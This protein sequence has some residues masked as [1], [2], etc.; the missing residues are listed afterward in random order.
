MSGMQFSDM[1]VM[2]GTAVLYAIFI[3]TT[4]GRAITRSSGCRIEFAFLRVAA[5]PFA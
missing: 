4:L 5:V 2:L 3:A 1:V